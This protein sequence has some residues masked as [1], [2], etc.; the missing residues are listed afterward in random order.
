MDP[1]LEPVASAGSKNIIY[2]V[3]IVVVVLILIGVMIWSLGF[4]K[5]KDPPC[6]ACPKST[7]RCNSIWMSKGTEEQKMDYVEAKAFCETNGSRIATKQ[8]VIDATIA[9]FGNCVG[10]WVN[11]SNDP[12]GDAGAA[13]YYVN[14]DNCGRG[15]DHPNNQWFG[16]NTVGE[17]GTPMSRKLEAYCVGPLPTKL[18]TTG[19]VRRFKFL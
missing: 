10:G 5:P 8:E 13:G 4:S 14:D 17:E 6:T 19:R 12:N 11:G 1:E 9:G 2:I 3:A 16:Y 15:E 7:K 18:P